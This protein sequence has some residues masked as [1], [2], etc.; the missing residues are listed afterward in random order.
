MINMDVS[1]TLKIA[2]IG[3]L[4]AFACQLLSKSGRDEQATLLSVAAMVTV[5]IV[6]VDKAKDLLDTLKS[7]FGI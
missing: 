3:L 1:L 6:I 4:T 2:G 7:V 5:F